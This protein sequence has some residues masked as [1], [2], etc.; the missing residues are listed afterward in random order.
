LLPALS[1]GPDISEFRISQATQQV[2]RSRGYNVLFPIQANTYDHI[3]D[4]K[5]VIGRALTGSGK[6]LS[7]VLP[8]VERLQEQIKDARPAYG[9]LPSVICLSPTRELARQ[10]AKDFDEIGKRLSTIC[11]YGGS[12]YG[13][14][15][16]ALR[17]GVDVVVGTPGRVMDHIQRGTLRLSE[18]KYVILDEADEMLNIG[19]K[20]DVD[21]ILSGAPEPG[22]RQTLLFSATIPPW[23]QSIANQH[24]RREETVT[25]DLVGK[26]ILQISIN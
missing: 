20:D 6:T 16:G 19:F 8:V 3:Y 15:E 26:L 7:F 22:K 14:Q 13:P 2:L 23:V 11:I 18:V 25:V 9:R 10:I 5:D 24:M 1:E 21:E 17:R 12:P 4:G